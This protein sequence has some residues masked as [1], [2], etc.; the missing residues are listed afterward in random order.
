MLIPGIP[1]AGAQNDTIKPKRQVEPTA[2]TEPVHGDAVQQV[3]RRRS[4]RGRWPERRRRKRRGM[5]LPET[6][7]EERGLELPEKGLLVDIKV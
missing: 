2:A 7:S 1:P 4:D 6:S 3:E 5:T